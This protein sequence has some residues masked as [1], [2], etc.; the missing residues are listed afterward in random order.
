MDSI[1]IDLPGVTACLGDLI[2]TGV[3]EKEQW[4][5]FGRL[6]KKFCEYGLR[7]KLRK[8]AFFKEHVEYFGHII[9]KDGKRPFEASV[10]TNDQLK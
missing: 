4:N 3:T 9:D 8:C 1:V 7:I 5:N 6:I 10:T 2:I